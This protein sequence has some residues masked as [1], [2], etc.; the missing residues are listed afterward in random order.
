MMHK[1]ILFASFAFFAA[2]LFAQNS[3]NNEKI[4]ELA[5]KNAQ[6]YCEC[7][8]LEAM[9]DLGKDLQDGKLIIDE[10]IEAAKP[11]MARV[12]ECTR[13]FV[14]EMRELSKEEYKFFSEESKKYRL[15]F[16][17]I[18]IKKHENKR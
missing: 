1:T 2:E 8:H 14:K 7:P 15:E 18:A 3:E 13:P 11:F 12:E 16:C 10:Y 9:F 5:K 4:S 6:A 17:A